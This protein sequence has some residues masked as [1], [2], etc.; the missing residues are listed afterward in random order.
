M[1]K[2]KR[3][4]FLLAALWIAAFICIGA[5]ARSFHRAP[6]VRAED[7]AHSAYIVREADGYVA[8]YRADA[9]GTPMQI[10]DIAVDDLR[11]HD[12]ELLRAGLGARDRQ[13]LLMLLEDLRE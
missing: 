3:T 9:P 5:T 12:R 6:G 13:A 4:W 2:Q 8:V 10:T 1:T 7:A 11:E